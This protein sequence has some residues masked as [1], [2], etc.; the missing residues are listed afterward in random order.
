VTDDPTDA[1]RWL[2][3]G[4]R[5]LYDNRWVRLTQVN[6]TAPDGHRWW[7]HVVRLQMVAAAL[8]VDENDRVLMM[9]RHRFVPDAFGWELPGGIVSEGE[10]GPAAAARETEEETGWRPTGP[11]R[12][13]ISFQPMPGMVDTPHEVYLFQGA[14]HVGEPTDAEEAG[15]VEW[16]PLSDV[17]KL[18]EQ[19]K[20]A[21]SGSLIGLLYFLASRDTER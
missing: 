11:G 4:E 3:H 1:P 5:T 17:T 9:W 2:V 8:V 13:L 19:G 18:A 16:V 15:H 21:G 10:S 20:V 12:H 6:L 7:H 14:K